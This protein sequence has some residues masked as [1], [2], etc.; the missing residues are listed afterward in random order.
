VVKRVRQPVISAQ[1]W[2]VMDANTG[3]VVHGYRHNER[4]C[5]ASMTKITTASVVLQLA[6]NNPWLLASKATVSRLVSS[7]RVAFIQRCAS[8]HHSLAGSDNDRYIS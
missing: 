5:V 1:A 3:A 6:A 4:R 8:I 7:R 2:I